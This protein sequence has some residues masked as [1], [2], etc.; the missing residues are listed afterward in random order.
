MELPPLTTSSSS[1]TEACASWRSGYYDDVITSAAATASGNGSV[2]CGGRI[3]S[4]SAAVSLNWLY[5]LLG[6][7]PT[8]IVGGNS[9]VLLALVRR[10][11]L[12]TL[13]NRVIASLAFTDLL[14]AVIV[15]PLG[16]YQMVSLY[17]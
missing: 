2:G 16:I 12:R 4:S 13:S 1:Q 10:R 14:L 9:L 8:W 11:I 17:R 15:V 7:V 6:V 5:L 3:E